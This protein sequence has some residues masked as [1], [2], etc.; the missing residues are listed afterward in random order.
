[1]EISLGM[2]EGLEQGRVEHDPVLIEH[3]QCHTKRLVDLL[4]HM[5]LIL[6]INLELGQLGQLLVACH[7]SRHGN[8]CTIA[9]IT[10]ARCTSVGTGTI[11]VLLLCLIESGTN[12]I[13]IA[14]TGSFVALVIGSV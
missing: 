13:R 7:G 9:T 4:I 10:A 8:W 2:E 6:Q 14:G 1:M 3:G 12:G 5:L 11:H